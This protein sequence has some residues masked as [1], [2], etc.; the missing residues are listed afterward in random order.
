M[1]TIFI[2]NFIIYSNINYEYIIKNKNNKK[3]IDEYSITIK[4][5]D[6]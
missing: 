3:E 6:C 4:G 1:Y 5:A 2:I